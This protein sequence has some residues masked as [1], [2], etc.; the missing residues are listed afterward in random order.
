MRVAELAVHQVRIPLKR[1]IRHASHARRDTE[2]LIVRRTLE[3]G[4]VGYGEGAP[5]D[6]VTGETLDGTWAALKKAPWPALLAEAP[7]AFAAALEAAERAGVSLVEPGDPR[8][9]RTNAG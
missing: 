7:S 1:T 4:Q 9:C 2:N 6:Y 8:R 5:R 3:T